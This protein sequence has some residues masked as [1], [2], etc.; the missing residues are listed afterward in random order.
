MIKTINS[1]MTTNSQLSTT[2]PKQKLEQ[3]QNHTNG[4][5]MEGYQKGWGENGGKG[6][7]NKKHKWYVQNRQDEL[8]YSIGNREPKELICSTHGHEL[9]RQGC[10]GRQGIEQRGIKGGQ[11]M[12]QL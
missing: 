9:R 11:E 6:T 3:E 8:K 5:H 7:G 1:K 2:E 10:C 12:G 4:D